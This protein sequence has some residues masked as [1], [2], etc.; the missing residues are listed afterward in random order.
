[1]DAQK[2]KIN[3]HGDHKFIEVK[4]FP[5]YGIYNYVLEIELSEIRWE[6]THTTLV[7][8]AHVH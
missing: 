2:L 5:N 7:T 6:K 8:H 3:Y 1:M 4:K